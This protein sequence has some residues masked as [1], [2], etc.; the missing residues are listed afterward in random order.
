MSKRGTRG[1]W[2][3]AG[4]GGQ[5]AN[6]ERQT[7]LWCAFL[8][9]F[10]DVKFMFAALPHCAELEVNGEVPYAMDRHTAI[11]HNNEMWI[12]G[13][14]RGWTLTNKIWKFNL[15]MQTL[16]CDINLD[17]DPTAVTLVAHC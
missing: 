16:C 10:P 14:D 3:G 9:L 1:P 7:V 12:F 4:Y 11:G 5:C 13:G 2:G 8:F 17:R 6:M 15:S